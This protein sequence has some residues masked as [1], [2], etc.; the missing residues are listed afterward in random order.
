MTNKKHIV[1]VSIWFYPLN[2]VAVNRINAFVKYLDPSKYDISVVTLLQDDSPK[3]E[4]VLG[5]NVYR[6]E[7]NKIVRNRRQKVGDPKLIHKLKSVN[8]ILIG[9]MGIGDFPGWK[10]SCLN[11]LEKIHQEQKVDLILSSFAPED[12]HEIALAFKKKYPSIKWIADMRDEMSLNPFYDGKRKAKLQTL[13]LE[14]EPHVDAI[15]SV[16]KPILDGFKSLMTRNSSIDFLE[17][18]NGFDHERE[19]AYNFND[20]FTMLYAGTFYAERKPSEFFK[21]LVELYEEGRLPEDIKIQLLGTHLNFKIPAVLKSK[22]EVLPSMPNDECLSYMFK[23]DCNLLLH[24][25]MGVKGV[26]TGK[27][28]EYLSTLKPVFGMVDMEDVAAELIQDLNGGICVDFHDVPAIKQ[29]FLDLYGQWK[30][31]EKQAYAVEKVKTLHRRGQT[32]IVEQEIEK[33][34]A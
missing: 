11:R 20:D 21:A 18:R 5:A 15:T 25:P 2:R 34:L 23:A 31:K 16:S 28:F 6:E 7:G 22:I 29:A 8:N 30:R 10:K 3:F 24:P 9:K 33:L 26:F 19:E 27:L 4:R 13:E 32:K 1:I 17:V 14:I 12:A